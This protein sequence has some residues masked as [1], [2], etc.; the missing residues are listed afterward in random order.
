MTGTHQVNVLALEFLGWYA[1]HPP[2]GLVGCPSIDLNKALSLFLEQ[3]NFVIDRGEG[4]RRVVGRL[5]LR[6]LLMLL[7]LRL[8]GLAG[9]CAGVRA[10][11]GAGRC[12]NVRVSYRR[13]PIPNIS[14]RVWSGRSSV[15]SGGPGRCRGRAGRFN[16]HAE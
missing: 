15:R 16:G 11:A 7:L 10:Y 9:L 3:C 8:S 13:L 6:L 4:R 14:G 2:P 12:R 1:A 5:L